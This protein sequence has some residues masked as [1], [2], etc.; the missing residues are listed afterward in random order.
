MLF[1]VVAGA[2][3][4][5]LNS[6]RPL[7]QVCTVGAVLVPL[8]VW[9]YG[10]IGYVVVPFKESYLCG[11][12]NLFLPFYG[13]YYLVSRWDVMRGV[14]FAHLAA[15][16]MII[17]P[18]IFLPAVVQSLKMQE[19][20]APSIGGAQRPAI[21]AAPP[22]PRQE[23]LAGPAPGFPGLVDSPPGWPDPGVP[24]PP[25]QVPATTTSITLVVTGLDDQA[26]GR[27]FGDKLGELAGKVSGGFLIS[28]SASGGK[29]TYSI[30]M[31]NPVDV[32]AFADQIT[33]ARVTRVSGQT[34]TIDAAE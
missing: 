14:F 3:V 8:A 19:G 30:S 2:I 11:V 21:A 31:V 32:K 4:L 29:S 17:L 7:A 6:P 25:V 20:E 15:L 1:G 10:D 16:G 12:M 33:W 23:I 22:R 26:R 5:A 18:A 13:L 24:P 27:A 28:S 34:I 9:L